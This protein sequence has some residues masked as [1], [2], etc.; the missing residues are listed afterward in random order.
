MKG[1]RIAAVGTPVAIIV[2]GLVWG[3]VTPRIEPLLATVVYALALILRRARQSNAFHGVLAVVIGLLPLSTYGLTLRNLPGPPR[4]VSCCCCVPGEFD[5]AVAAQKRGE[6]VV[7]SD[8]V[9]GFE[10]K[11]YL[12]W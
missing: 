1:R 6:C 12:V 9:S 2:L 11:W 5:R 4:F 3:V 7:C 10:P 8:I